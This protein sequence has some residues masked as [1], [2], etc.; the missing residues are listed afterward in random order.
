MSDI[1]SSAV[2]RRSKPVIADDEDEDL[3]GSDNEPQQQPAKK[4]ED[5]NNNDNNEQEVDDLFG[6]EPEDNLNDF[7][8]K[9]GSDDEDDDQ[10]LVKTQAEAKAGRELK[11]K[12]LDIVRHPPKFYQEGQDTPVYDAKI[13]SYLKIQPTRFDAASF[14]KYVDSLQ[15]LPR[16]KLTLIKLREEN[17][18]RWRFNKPADSDSLEMESN[19]QIVE[20]DDGSMSL[21]LGDEFFDVIQTK[22]HDTYLTTQTKN[23]EEGNKDSHSSI[24]LSD[25]KL[26]KSFKFVPTSTKSKIHK[27]FTS[28][29]LTSR[30]RAKPAVQS[31]FVNVDPSLEG[32]KLEKLEDQKIRERRKELLRLE[33]ENESSS[34]QRYNS[35]ES[36]S[37][38]YMPRSRVQDSYEK[39]DFLADDDEEEDEDGYGYDDDEDE[40]DAAAE[41]LQRVKNQGRARYDDD[42]E[43]EED[44]DAGV[45]KKRRVIDDDED[46]E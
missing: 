41:R 14:S 37:Q 3:F 28:A 19:A 30:T 4:E 35:R 40:D 26:S 1:D 39:D 44:E 9:D 18:I 29:L 21:K 17:T 22:V 11:Q 32:K 27:S 45:R 7:V 43:E 16:E 24:Y 13:P 15:E 12:D 8:D 5:S 46:D 20:W 33:R 6:D 2:P 42:E 31:V 25:G 34:S 38:P 23:Q 10:F 36:S